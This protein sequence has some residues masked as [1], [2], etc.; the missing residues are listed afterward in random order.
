VIL[1]LEA[2]IIICCQEPDTEGGSY[3]T[4]YEPEFPMPVTETSIDNGS[5]QVRVWV[6]NREPVF[7]DPVQRQINVFAEF[8]NAIGF[9]PQPDDPGKCHG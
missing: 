8:I 5:C 3:I 1:L 7:E 2:K 9:E 4:V 6:I